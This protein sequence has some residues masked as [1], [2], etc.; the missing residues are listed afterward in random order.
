MKSACALWF[1][2]RFSVMFYLTLMITACSSNS[3]TA[4]PR[5][6]ATPGIAKPQSPL[7]GRI[8]FVSGQNDLRKI[9]IVSADGS[10]LHQLTDNAPRDDNPQWSP[11]GTQIAFESYYAGKPK[12]FVINAD[13]TNLHELPANGTGDL[14][15]FWSP[16]AKQFVFTSNQSG[17]TQVFVMDADGSNSKLLT[18]N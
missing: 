12:I 18:D 13:G 8:A 5:I 1:F 15:P 10:K 6:E 2:Q 11:D 7:N 9:Y 16:E 3:T 17:H 4:T 14:F